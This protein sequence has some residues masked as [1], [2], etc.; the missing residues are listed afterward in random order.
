MLRGIGTGFGRLLA[1]ADLARRHRVLG[2]NQRRQPRH[3]GRDQGQAAAA[4]VK[5]ALE[6]SF[7][8]RQ[9]LQQKSPIQR[10]RNNLLA[11]FL[12]CA[13]A[14]AVCGLAQLHEGGRHFLQVRNV[15]FQ[16]LEGVLDLQRK[17]PPQTSPV[18]GCSG[19]GLIEHLY[20]HR[21]TGV[22][23]GRVANQGLCALADLQQLGQF[24]KCPAGV[25]LTGQIRRSRAR[26][27]FRSHR[28]NTGVA[29]CHFWL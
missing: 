21:V 29:W 17:Q 8:R 14:R 4:L 19:L 9:R 16:V 7:L 3:L 28:G 11:Q 2:Q 25:A 5:P 26:Y 27:F 10:H 13:A 20:R 24:A 15:F 18:A 6:I 1:V 23:Q 12:Q 22:N